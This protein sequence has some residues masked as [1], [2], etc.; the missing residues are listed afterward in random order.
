VV[1][2]I[3][4]NGTPTHGTTGRG[5]S[6]PAKLSIRGRGRVTLVVLPIITSV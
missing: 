4:F 1:R 6:R 2:S 5:S 3:G